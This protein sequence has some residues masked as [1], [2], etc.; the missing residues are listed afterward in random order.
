MKPTAVVY[1]CSFCGKDQDAVKKLIA[2][3]GGVYICDEC[4]A[5]CGQIIEE[6]VRRGTAEPATPPTAARADRSDPDRAPATAAPQDSGD[7]DPAASILATLLTEIIGVRAT[8]DALGVDV[9]ALRSE[10][11][12]LRTP[13]G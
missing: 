9:G 4:V 3:P 2:G 8:L 1:T 10:V 12:A 13:R 11:A 7:S 5:L 6:E